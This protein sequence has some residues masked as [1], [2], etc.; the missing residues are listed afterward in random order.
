MDPSTAWLLIVLSRL[1]LRLGGTGDLRAFQT[2]LRGSLILAACAVLLI[3][4]TPFLADY[5]V[6]NLVLFL[7]LFT[8]GFLTVKIP[9]INFWMEFAFLTTSAFVALN[10]QEPVPSQT[11]IDTFIGIMFGMLIATVVGRLLWPLLPQRILRD[12]LLTI[13]TQLKSLLGGDPHQERIRTQLT[14]LLVDALGALRQIRIAGCS[15]EEKLKVT[16]LIRALRVL[17]A[18]ITQLAGAGRDRGRDSEGERGP[19]G[20]YAQVSRPHRAPIRLCDGL[21]FRCRRCCDC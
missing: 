12:S 2:R 4:T 13:L 16:A 9:G 11:I 19:A 15:E 21:Q 17:V 14:I 10:P 20:R 1:F 3:L 6:M 5:A 18:R 7:V 8:I